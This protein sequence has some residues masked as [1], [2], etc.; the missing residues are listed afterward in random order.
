MHS[1][2]SF[3][4]LF[5]L[6][7]HL[8][9]HVN[10]KGRNLLHYAV[11]KRN[12]NMVVQ[13]MHA[14]KWLIDTQDPYG[15][16]PLQYAIRIKFANAVIAMI[17]FQPTS[18]EQTTRRAKETLL[19]LAV[20]SGKISILC[21]LIAFCP[22]HIFVQKNVFEKTPLAMALIENSK[23]AKLLVQASFASLD[24]VDCAEYTP[25]F[26]AAI[27]SHPDMVYYILKVCPRVID[28]KL[29]NGKN[30]LYFVYD[31]KM[32]KKLLQLNPNLINAIT[33]KGKC[34]LHKALNHD[35]RYLLRFLLKSKPS[36]LLHR[37]NKK[38]SALHDAFKRGSTDDVNTI[39]SFKPD[40]I[41][42]DEDGNTVLHIAVEDSD[43]EVIANV[44][45]NR[46]SNLYCENSDGKTPMCLA[47][48]KN[49]RFA[50]SLFEPHM[51]LD[52]AM[53][54]RD[55]CQTTCGID[56]Q[57]RC[58]QECASL[59]NHLLPELLP[60]V[61]QYLGMTLSKKRKIH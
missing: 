12:L 37:D 19:H 13:V 55:L 15:E 36:L 22:P 6:H 27:F 57:P 18:I 11:R 34:V 28:Q 40:L 25:V 8:L 42:T 14:A 49:R 39:L 53:R 47:V 59:N 54:L 23:M 52:R 60:L 43:S 56:L 24:V 20:H 5:K 16:T 4:L 46:M 50:V 44:F 9:I 45:T 30:L 10:N 2:A 38:A 31:T 35:D 17:S 1:S 7:P 3:D 61:F 41:D 51:E 26:A 48:E 21:G 33:T 29:P 58:I 32:A